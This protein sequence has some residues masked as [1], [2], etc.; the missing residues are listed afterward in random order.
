VSKRLFNLKNVPDDEAHDVR[1]L[2]NEHGI[3]FY[4]TPARFWIFS[5]AAI[6]LVDAADF[7]K[8]RQIIDQYQVQRQQRQ[9]E[10]YLQAK[11]AGQAI[12]V[13]KLFLSQPLRF[14]LALLGITVVLYFSLKPFLTLG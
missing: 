3:Q 9:R 1:N 2:L 7:D 14:V 11:Q 6:W 12:T 10:L 4:E 13:W 8:A 5:M